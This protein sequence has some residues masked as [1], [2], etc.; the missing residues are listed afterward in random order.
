MVSMTPDFAFV[1]PS[2]EHRAW[3][4]SERQPA[5]SLAEQ[6]NIIGGQFASLI[7]ASGR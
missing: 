2:R 5:D 1:A 3:W 7:F 4:S 6:W